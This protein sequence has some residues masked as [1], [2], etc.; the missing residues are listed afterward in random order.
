MRRLL[1]MTIGASALIVGVASCGAG[2]DDKLR[3]IDDADLFGLDETSTSTSTTSTTT[4]VSI[5][6]TLTPTTAPATE[7]V[8]LYFLDGNRLQP[9]EIA[10]A[11]E[12][13]LTRVIAA[14]LSGP[15][16]GDLGIGLRTLL[17]APN[18]V[19]PPLVLSVDPS[20]AGYA[21]VDLSART[22]GLI[23]AADQRAAIAQIVLTIVSS[24]PGI[25][26]VKFTLDGKPASVP[27]KDGLLSGPGEAV[28]LQ[29][30]ESLLI[31]VTPPTTTTSSTTTLP[32][33]PPSATG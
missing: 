3:R 5:D 33:P 1:A 22:F 32:A 6:S 12:A 25:G 28:S 19:D 10:L 11:G 16:A 26:Q 30:Y 4:P 13:S 31:E 14:L 8:H 7:T 9:V 29:D 17:P 23:D 21:T 2:G 27:R 20:S 24:R 18:G 15:P